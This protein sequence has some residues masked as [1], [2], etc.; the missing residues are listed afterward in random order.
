MH[1]GDQE[2]KPSPLYFE[3]GKAKFTPGGFVDFTSI[4]RSTNLGSGIATSFGSLPYSNTTQGRL[5]EFHFSAQYSRLSLKVDAPVT[6]STSL[7]GYVETD[8]LGYQPANAYI[9][10]NSNSLRMRIFWAQIKHGN[11][12]VL[13]S[14]QWSLLTPNRVGLSPLTSDLFFT[15]VEDP[16]FQVGLTW[17]RQAQFRVT[18]HPTQKWAVAVSLENPQQFAPASVVFPSATYLP[19]FDNGSSATNAAS[20]TTN[21]SVPNSP[22]IIVKTSYDTQFRN[23]RFISKWLACCEASE[24]LNTLA[25]LEPHGYHHRWWGSINLNFHWFKNLTAVASSFYSDGGGRYFGLGPDAI[26]ARR[27]CFRGALGSG[28]GFEWQVTLICTLPYYGGALT[29]RATMD[30]C[31]SREVLAPE[32]PDSAGRFRFPGSANT[33]NRAV[34]KLPSERFPRCGPTPTTESSGDHR[35]FLLAKSVVCHTVR[36]HRKRPSEH[37]L[38]RICNILHVTRPASRRDTWQLTS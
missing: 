10:A 9:T 25:T 12:D 31:R 26:K 2:K 29:S 36:Q 17:A 23:T 13:G 28:A 22:D 33:S 20:A 14:Q 21:T 34:R 5:S 30:S 3:I 7:T 1:D 27:K 24:V 19:Q 38:R 37:G 4:T 32:S 11:W 35:T 8:F 6:D 18:Y 16:N 15:L